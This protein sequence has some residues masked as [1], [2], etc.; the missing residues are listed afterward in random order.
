MDHIVNVQYE[1]FLAEV[2]QEIGVIIRRM[3]HI[4]ILLFKHQFTLF[5][6]SQ[7]KVGGTVSNFILE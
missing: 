5:L 7:K 3:E 1:W 4:E 6:V 2:F